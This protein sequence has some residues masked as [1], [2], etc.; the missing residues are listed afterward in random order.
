MG[1][2]EVDVIIFILCLTYLRISKIHCLIH[3]LVDQ[4]HVITHAIL[5]KFLPQISLENLDKLKDV[6]ENKSRVDIRAS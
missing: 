2:F 4:S 5:V 1:V 3:K 6:L